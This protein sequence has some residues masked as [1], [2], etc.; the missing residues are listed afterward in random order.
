MFA[1][2]SQNLKRSS[3]SSNAPASVGCSL[4]PR[5]G[6]VECG[7]NPITAHL[8]SGDERLWSSPTGRT[9]VDLCSL[10]S[11]FT[12]FQPGGGTWKERGQHF[13]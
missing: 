13:P 12:A 2:L 6:G 1:V 11:A 10:R 3:L 7:L 5:G 4:S 8:P 9:F